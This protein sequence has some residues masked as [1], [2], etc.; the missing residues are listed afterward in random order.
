MTTQ[1]LKKTLYCTSLREEPAP[2]PENGDNGEWYSVL[3]LI[4]LLLNALLG[5]KRKKKK[6]KKT[7]S[8]IIDRRS[9]I[10]SKCM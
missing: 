1:D 4:E 5:E 2:F 3:C 9:K 6:K 7:L 8:I 10:I